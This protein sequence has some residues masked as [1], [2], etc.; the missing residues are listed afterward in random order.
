MWKIDNK[1]TR[2]GS[3]RKWLDTTV[4]STHTSSPPPPPPR[5][6]ESTIHEL[7]Q[8]R[9]FTDTQTQTHMHACTLDLAL[10]SK[11]PSLSFSLS[12]SLS[13]ISP[14]PSLSFSRPL[15]ITSYLPFEVFIHDSWH[16]HYVMCQTLAHNAC[17]LTSLLASFPLAV[18]SCSELFTL[19]V[20]VA[21]L[22]LP[23]HLTLQKKKIEKRMNNRVN[24]NEVNQSTKSLH[25]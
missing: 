20:P 5:F 14:S 24:I 13:L 9:Q 11:P 19:P 25:K 12:L 4:V 15:S 3:E 17:T 21:V 2:K 22:K 16:R 10:P 6:W 18:P 23:L 7:T 8:V 1:Y